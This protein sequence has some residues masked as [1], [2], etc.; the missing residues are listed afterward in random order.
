MDLRDKLDIVIITYNRKKYLKET[1][2]SLFAE[3]SPIKDCNI[4]ILDNDS[5][6]GTEEMTREFCRIYPNVKLVKNK[7]N[8]GGNPNVAKA[9]SEYSTK[10]YIWLLCDNDKYCWSNFTEIENAMNEGYDVIFTQNCKDNI[11]DMFYKATFAPGCIYKTENFTP[12]AI[13]NM[14]D[15]IR[16]LFPHLALFAYNVNKDNRIFIPQ[17]DSIIQVI[18]PEDNRTIFNRGMETELIPRPRRDIL[19]LVGYINSIEL[20]SDKNKHSVIIE[21]CRHYHKSLYQLFKTFMIQNKYD[22]NNYGYNFSQIFRMLNF[23]QKL[24]FIWAYL[25][26]NLSFKNYKYYEIRTYEDWSEYLDKIDEQHYIDILSKI[27]N[28]KKVLLYGA[29]I[30]SQ[31]LADKYDLSNLNIVGISDKRFENFDENTYKGYKAIKPNELKNTEFD[32]ILFTMKLY[33]NIETGLRKQGI[34][35]KSLPLIKKDRK[36]VIRVS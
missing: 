23:S 30:V 3:D 2:N 29:G 28:G 7:I 13:G 18:N 20:I 31:V 4:T 1:L 19:W 35:Q 17:N 32:Y 6:D 21:G 8:I 34:T 11:A 14:Y 12:T 15:N 25:V 33:K 22:K 36:Y 9:Y 26:V 16:F 24:R 5:T 10:E 27:F